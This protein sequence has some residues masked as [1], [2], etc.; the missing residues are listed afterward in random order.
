M[1]LLCFLVSCNEAKE[2]SFILPENAFF[3]ISGDSIKTWK[4]E[5]RFNNSH[6]MNMG[7]CFLSYRVSYLRNNTMYDNNGNY[8]NCGE[9]LKASWKIFTNENGSF[10]KLYSE[11][12]PKLLNQKNTYKYFQL[13]EISEEKL[14][15]RFEHRQFSNSVSIIEDHL[16]PDS[17][18]VENRDF[19]Y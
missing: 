18:V 11:Q 12:L 1:V 8:S 19:H 4:L 3:L 10:I 7:D 15:I 6:R 5:K 16:V 14:I 2:E 13:K 9:S 17:V